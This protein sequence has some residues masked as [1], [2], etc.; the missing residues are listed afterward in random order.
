VKEIIKYFIEGQA[1]GQASIM[2]LGNLAGDI[3]RQKKDDID[4]TT[5]TYIDCYVLRNLNDLKIQLLMEDPA[6][7]DTA[8]YY[9]KSIIQ[10]SIKYC[11]AQ[12]YAWSVDYNIMHVSNSEHGGG[13]TVILL[14]QKKKYLGWHLDL[15]NQKKRGIDLLGGKQIG[16]GITI[17]QNVLKQKTKA[18]GILQIY[19]DHPND[20]ATG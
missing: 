19:A 1:P 9:Y 18:P 2:I 12:L 14:T 8:C 17:C 15:H 13:P 11:F 3:L 7:K 10:N 16:R 4:T 6:Y 20:H 5:D